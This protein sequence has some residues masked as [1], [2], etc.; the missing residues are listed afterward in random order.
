MAQHAAVTALVENT[1]KSLVMHACGLVFFVPDER[2]R[3][4]A[5][6]GRFDLFSR[7]KDG[8]SV[9]SGHDSPCLQGASP[10]NVR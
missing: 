10:I 8:G 7:V 4:K 9:R 1:R 5:R 6:L 2:L 3:V